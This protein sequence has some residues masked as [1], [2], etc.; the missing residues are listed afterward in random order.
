ME[1]S[2]KEFEYT[3]LENV[4]NTLNNFINLID[5]KLKEYQNILFETHK[6]INEFSYELSNNPEERGDLFNKIENIEKQIESLQ[7][8]KKQ[9]LK[10]LNSAYFGRVDFQKEG[11][12]SPK[13]IYIGL[14]SIQENSSLLVHDWRADVSSLYYDGT[15]GKTSY[16]APIGKISGNMSL[17]RQYKIEN[18]KLK[19]YFDSNMVIDDDILKEELSKN[20]T[21]KMKN[22]VSTIQKEQNILIRS[23]LNHNLLVQGVAGSGK[24]SV[25]LHRVSFL[26]YKYKNTL[27]STDILI[28]SPSNKFSN[29]ISQ[30]LP[31]IN[32]EN[33]YTTTFENIAFNLYRLKYIDRT[34]YI[35]NF[36]K[37]QDEKISKVINYKSNFDFLNKLLDFITN[38]LRKRFLSQD[39]ILNSNAI[40]KDDYIVI[41]KKEIEKLYNKLNHLDVYN[42]IEVVADNLQGYV[43]NKKNYKNIIKKQL[44]KMFGK[45]NVINLYEEFL[46]HLGL[47]IE[48]TLNYLDIPAILIIQNELFGLK[49]EYETKYIVIDEMQDF[50]PCHLYLFSK[51]WNCSR[52]YLGDIN[53]CIEKS[54]NKNYLLSLKNIFNFDLVYLTKT[55]RT[56]K[57]ISML[58]SKIIGSNDYQTV[59]RVSDEPE[60][61]KSNDYINVVVKKILQNHDRFNL[62]AIL[63]KTEYECLKFKEIL[64]TKDCENMLKNVDKNKIVIETIT[65]AKGVE[66]DYVILLDADESHYNSLIDK[67]LLYVATTRALHKID[68]IYK[69]NLTRFLT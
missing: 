44:Y 46:T 45:L 2:S 52:I 5:D 16:I 23:D 34:T 11:A 26:L 58:A 54:L 35:N 59:E 32:D 57:Q 53:Q 4:N 31:S 12:E 39:I 21:S 38:D 29:Y 67:N 49:N 30:V 19:Y 47:P 63:L 55:Y 66:Y 33:A 14:G 61:I 56:S 13:I 24:T 3:Y 15:I 60:F 9:Y 36:L 27:K 1:T 17:K 64:S 7:S 68:Y 42:R 50:T 48:K 51:L 28:I 22:I 6:Y 69:E 41:D 40:S 43:N 8:T 62:I 37:T 25:A 65:N 10:Q 18:G 20:T